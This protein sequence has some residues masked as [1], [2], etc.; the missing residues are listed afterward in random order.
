VL[1]AVG[2]KNVSVE[3]GPVKLKKRKSQRDELNRERTRSSKL[4]LES[5]W[6]NG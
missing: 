3:G 2:V 6:S 5:K 4:S 1:T